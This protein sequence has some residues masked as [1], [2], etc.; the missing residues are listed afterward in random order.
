MFRLNAE[1]HVSYSR[2]FSETSG[3]VCRYA[4][5]VPEGRRLAAPDECLLIALQVATL[6]AT[7]VLTSRATAATYLILGQFRLGAPARYLPYPVVGGFL[8]VF[9]GL[10]FLAAWLIDSWRSLPRLDYAM[11]FVITVLIATFG[12]VTGVAA[13]LALAIT[14][15][16]MPGAGKIG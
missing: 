11:V 14:L 3:F 5:S 1:R 6:A 4:T 7:I 2:I 12:M 16:L 15:C 10:S 13:G 9:L 8:A